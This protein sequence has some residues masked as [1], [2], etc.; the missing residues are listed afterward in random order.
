VAHDESA[1]DGQNREFSTDHGVSA[2]VERGGDAPEFEARALSLL[3]DQ[4]ALLQYVREA[5]YNRRRIEQARREWTQAFDAID[6]PLFMHDN[7]CRVTRANRAYAREVGCEDIRSLLGRPYYE[8]FPRRSTPLLGC[9]VSREALEPRNEMLHLDDGRIFESRTFPIVD[10]AGQ[11]AQALHIMDDV[12]ERYRAE[13]TVRTL[14]S[15]MEQAA[16]GMLVADAGLVVT[17]ANPA[18]RRLV[19]MEA[20]QIVGQPF[21]ALFAREARSVVD[22]IPGQ[23]DTDRGGGL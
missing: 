16:E 7:D 13:E 22:A 21:G 12:T 11:Y 20:E 23:A 2:P 10:G 15:A 18:V 1:T 17:Y 19:G 4:R 6:L 9:Q 5:E 14:S 8:L 3:D